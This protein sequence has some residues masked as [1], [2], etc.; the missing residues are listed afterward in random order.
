M[1]VARTICRRAER[2]AVGLF[3][4]GVLTNPQILSYLNRL[5][6]HL[7][8]SARHIARDSGGDILWRPGATR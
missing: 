6:D 1:D 3:E 2:L 8:V 4:T 7:F 5:S